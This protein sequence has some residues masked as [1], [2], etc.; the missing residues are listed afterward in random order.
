MSGQA[1]A[2]AGES[3]D[4]AR[5]SARARPRHAPQAVAIELSADA[6][7]DASEASARGS[8]A[9]SSWS[10]GERVGQCSASHARGEGPA[11]GCTVSGDGIRTAYTGQ[12]ATFVIH[13]ADPVTGE[14]RCEGGERF[15]VSLSGAA[16]TRVRVF[17]EGDGSY[18]CQYKCPSSGKYRLSI[19]TQSAH[20]PGSPF[21]VVVKACGNLKEW[22]ARQAK[23]AAELKAAREERKR[24]RSAPV[25]KRPASPRIDPA[26]QLQKAYALALASIR[27]DSTAAPHDAH[28]D[29]YAWEHHR[30][31]AADADGDGEAGGAGSGG[32][33]EEGD[34]H[35]PGTLGAALGI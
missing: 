10:D 21:T 20:V 25:Q 16:S 29:A 6:L 33:S 11:S 9:L 32:G 26:E 3:S 22:K 31:H 30:E 34:T 19:M 27:T 13:A 23:E 14:R 4:E 7:S 8:A 28:D 12:T 15:A 35:A 17:D 1:S 5:P 2:G 18:V 24:E